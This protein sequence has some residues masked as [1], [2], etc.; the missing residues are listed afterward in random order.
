MTGLVIEFALQTSVNIKPLFMNV[1]ITQKWL[2]S[3]RL[4]PYITLIKLPTII[5]LP[6]TKA[7]LAVK[8]C[9]VIV[10]II[11]LILLLDKEITSTIM[12]S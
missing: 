7:Y 8:I 3:Q 12:Q 11:N 1:I 4:L 6:S 10:G 2:L 9:I 5:R